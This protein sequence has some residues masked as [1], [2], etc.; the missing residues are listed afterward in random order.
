[1]KHDYNI[2]LNSLL[3]RAPTKLIVADIDG[4]LID[5][6]GNNDGLDELRTTLADLDETT[7]F[8]FATGRNL[9][10]IEQVVKSFDLPEADFMI[11]SVGSAIYYDYNEAS[12]D[13]CWDDHIRK[14]WNRSNLKRSLATFP[15]LTLQGEEDQSKTKL[16][17]YTDANNFSFEALQ[18]KLKKQI[19]RITLTYSHNAFLDILPIK[20]SKAKAI[21]FIA[22]KLL[23][24]ND[25]IIVC[26]DSGNDLDM[27]DSE[28]KSIIVANHSEELSFLREKENCYFTSK[29]TAEGVVEG[30]K[31]WNII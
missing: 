25:N 19:N 11:S 24:S 10:S 5:E 18:E 17:Y 6:Q 26:G 28:F 13:C 23:I 29:D 7:L 4:T 9:K 12:I 31:H 30:L 14:G 16:S 21:S 22:E 3:D 1:M 27:L 20:A 15:G 2:F 8:A